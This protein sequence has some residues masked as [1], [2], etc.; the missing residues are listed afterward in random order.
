MT[1]HDL[2]TLVNAV[3]LMVF[4]GLSGATVFAML[5]RLVAYRRAS[6]PIP[7]LLKRGLVLIGAFLVIGAEVVLLRAYDITL[8]EDSLERLAFIVQYDL[9]ILS[10]LGYYTKVEIFDVDDPEKP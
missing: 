8:A 5:L 4:V 7:A 2:I 3:A 6:Q 9:I 1:I 10:A